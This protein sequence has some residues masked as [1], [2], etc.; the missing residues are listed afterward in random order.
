MI[1]AKHYNLQELLA[2]FKSSLACF[3]LTGNFLKK[4][5][6]FSDTTFLDTATINNKYLSHDICNNNCLNFTLPILNS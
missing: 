6:S 2:V 3:G 5:S 1:K 4:F